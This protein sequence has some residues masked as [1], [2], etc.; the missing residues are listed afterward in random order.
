MISAMLASAPSELHIEQPDID[1][2]T[3]PNESAGA[4]AP[5][6]KNANPADMGP[7]I[8][9]AALL[10]GEGAT[11]VLRVEVLETGAPGRIEV[12][13]SSGSRQVDEAAVDYARTRRWVAGRVNGIPQTTWIRWGVRMQA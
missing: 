5:I 1:F 6:I 4:S 12:D 2:S 13:A 9:R 11:V 7:F 8:A 3:S 10:H